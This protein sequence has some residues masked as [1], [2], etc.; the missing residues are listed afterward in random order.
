MIYLVLMFLIQSIDINLMIQFMITVSYCFAAIL[1]LIMFYKFCF[2]S[3]IKLLLNPLLLNYQN[4]WGRSDEKYGN[5]FETVKELNIEFLIAII[6]LLDSRY[7]F[8]SKTRIYIVELLYYALV[9]LAEYFFR[10]YLPV[11]KL[12]FQWEIDSRSLIA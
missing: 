12:T 11:F 2:L 9:I 4:F 10:S 7:Q 5:G 6:V 8:Y 3:K 1:L